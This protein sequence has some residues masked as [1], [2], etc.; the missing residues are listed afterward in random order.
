MAHPRSILRRRSVPLAVL[1]LSLGAPRAARAQADSAVETGALQ[2]FKFKQPI[3][4]EHYRMTRDSTGLALT[5]A[6]EFTDRFRRVSL[7]ASLETG[8][9]LTPRHFATRWIPR[10]PSRSGFCT[11]RGSRSRSWSRVR[12]RSHPSSEPSSRMRAPRA[13]TRPRRPSGSGISSASSG[14]GIG[15]G[16]RSWRGID[17]TVPGYSLHREQELYVAAGKRAD[18]LVVDGDPLRRITDLRRVRL[19][20]A[21]GRR[22]DPAPLWRSLGFTP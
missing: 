12:S 11:P 4:G 20:V 22:Y 16:F 6:F 17:Q 3:G 1:L 5:T 7:T 8:P 13:S 2:L 9:D 18:L 19:V 14:R 10:S 21:N 15:R